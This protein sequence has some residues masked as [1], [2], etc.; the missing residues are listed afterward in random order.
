MAIRQTR[1]YAPAIAPY[2]S[3][4]WAE[5][6]M[7]RIIRPLVINNDRLK[8]VWLTRYSSAAPEF[9]DSDGTNVPTGYFDNKHCRSLRFRF[10][11]VDDELAAFEQHGNLLIQ[12]DGCWN[13]DWRDYGIGELSSNRFV[14]EDRSQARRD[15]RL[16]LVKQY[17]ESV[18]RLMLHALVPA[19]TE[20]RFRV[21]NN[22]DNENPNNSAFFSL[23]HLFCNTTEV[24]LT[25]LVSNDGFMIDCGTRQYPQ[26]AVTQN[27]GVPVKEFRVRF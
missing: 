14:G 27:Q 17:L 24:L 3:H 22:D 11:I 13:A 20:G 1:I 15:E 12:Q 4:I 19:D 21:E 6:M 9:A 5:T 10:E 18:T 16:L 23:H 7:A 2:D 25:A 8:W 26:A